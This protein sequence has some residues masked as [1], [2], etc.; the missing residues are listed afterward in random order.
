MALNE[1]PELRVRREEE[2]A[3]E[4]GGLL[5]LEVRRL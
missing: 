3:Q 2:G 4:V 1:P 5:G